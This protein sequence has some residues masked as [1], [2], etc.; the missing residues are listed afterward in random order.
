MSPPRILY[1]R[2]AYAKVIDDA[3]KDEVL[4][5]LAESGA[6][7]DAVA[8]LC[9]L[10]ARNDRALDRLRKETPVRIAACY[11]RAVRWLFHGA[12]FPLPEDGVEVLNMRE[13]G[14]DEVVARLLDGA[15]PEGSAAPGTGGDA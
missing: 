8:D 15:R 3:V 14:A 4:A 12:G 5:R 9:E 2:C 10:A 6:A 1:C 13:S 11:P 7:F